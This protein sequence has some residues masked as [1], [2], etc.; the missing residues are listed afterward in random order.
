MCLVILYVD[1]LLITG[2]FE[3]KIEQLRNELKATFEMT[4]LGL[5]SSALF[6][7]YGVIFLSQHRYHRQLLETYDMTNC[8]L[9]S[10][11]MD[12][13]SKLSH[14][15]HSHILPTQDQICPTV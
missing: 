6:L 5:L 4:N 14:G 8:E 1:N 13:Q 2:S 10:Y 9:L 11:P 7:G 3:A 12:P 15:G